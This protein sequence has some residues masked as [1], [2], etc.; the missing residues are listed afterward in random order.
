MKTRG[1]RSSIRRNEWFAYGGL[2]LLAVAAFWV[3]AIALAPRPVPE[4]LAPT[5]TVSAASMTATAAATSPSPSPTTTTVP[6]ITVPDNPSVLIMGDSYTA[7]WGA[8][9]ETDGWAHV[10]GSLMNVTPL[11]DGIPGT[12]FAW[13][14]GANGD[15][16]NQF[17][18]RL[19]LIAAERQ[20]TPDV[21]ILQG[22]QNDALLGDDAA[23]T[24]AV[25]STVTQAKE[26]WPGIQIVIMGPTAPEPLAATLKK[27]NAA[28]SA[29]ARTA[30]VPFIDAYGEQWFTPENSV[31]F[32]TDGAHVNS[33]GHNLIAER[34][35]SHWSE[36]TT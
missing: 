30:G 28:V 8:A 7:S 9:A 21:L 24:K 36:L 19:Q 4:A 29:G 6:A 16:G 27:T 3:A 18:A 14:G 2:G 26:L 11:I 17:S 13:G 22:G 20:Y 25:T 31:T 35:Y 34:F 5:G 23:V 10:V 32:N 33:A 1:G 12:G 15:D